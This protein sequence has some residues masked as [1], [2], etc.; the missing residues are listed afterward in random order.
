MKRLHRSDLYCWSRFDADRNIDFHSYAWATPGGC[1]VIDPLPCSAHDRAHLD[2]LGG[3]RLVIV[4]NSDH[5]RASA[6]LAA[7]ADVPVAGPAAER[8]EFP[9]ACARWL[10]DGEEPVPGLRVL[11][12]HGSKTPGELALLIDDDTLITGDLVRAHAGGA[13]CLLPAAKLSDPDAARAS[14]ERLAGL[15]GIRAVLP[16]DGWPVFRDGDRLLR[17]LAAGLAGAEGAAIS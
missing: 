16:G 9:V 15:P 4:T 13:L 7:A 12:L 2:E 10:G 6:E 5:A 17:E 8:G 3:V 11:E 14:V 1:V